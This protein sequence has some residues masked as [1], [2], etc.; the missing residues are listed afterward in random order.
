MK[1][2]LCVT[3]LMLI[4]CM[5]FSVVSV[6]AVVTTEY[7]YMQNILSNVDLTYEDEIMSHFYPEKFNGQ[8]HIWIY[9]NMLYE[10]N[11]GDYVVFKA[12]TGCGEPASI[13]EYFGDYR[14]FGDSMDHPYELGYYVYVPAEQKVYTLREAW[15]SEE[16][17]ITKA[18]E[19]G[20]IGI[21]KYDVNLDAK[22]DIMDATYIQ[23]FV[24]G[25]EGYKSS[26]R[27][28]FD[29]DGEYAIM[30]ATAIQRHIAGLE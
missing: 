25:F 13:S 18:F 10:H 24:A 19:S 21:Y 1:K 22:F 28:D 27:M 12:L 11:D 15:D 8:T 29:Q 7:E 23:M 14:V 26:Y 5:M 4:I 3:A 9:Y 6:S 2:L 20:R 30:D 17:D 16:L